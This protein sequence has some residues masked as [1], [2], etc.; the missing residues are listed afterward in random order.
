MSFYFKILNKLKSIEY[1][2]DVF[3]ASQLQDPPITDTPIVPDDLHYGRG[4]WTQDVLLVA[5]PG[6]YSIITTLNVRNF[7]SSSDFSISQLINWW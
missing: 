7:R 4:E 5:H 2:V 1:G 6:T 3:M